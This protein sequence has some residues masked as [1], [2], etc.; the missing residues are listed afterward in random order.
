LHR[1]LLSIAFVGTL[2]VRVHFAALWAL[3]R[4]AQFS[5]GRAQTGSTLLAMTSNYALYNLLTYGDRR[6]WGH[7]WLVDLLSFYAICGIGVVG[8]V[9]VATA[10]FERQDGWVLAGAAGALFGTVLTYVATAAV[11]WK[12]P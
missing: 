3:F 10:V 2:G 1:A 4:G 12:R 9:G 11:T 8:N 6:R 7:R 5:L